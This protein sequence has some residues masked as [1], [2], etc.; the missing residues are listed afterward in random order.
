MINK[1][2]QQLDNIE[3]EETNKGGGEE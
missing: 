3:R 2:I 1:N